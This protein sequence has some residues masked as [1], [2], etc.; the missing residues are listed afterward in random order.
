M[1]K[2]LGYEGSV[3]IVTRALKRSG[4]FTLPA[5]ETKIGDILIEP[6]QRELL[7]ELIRQE[8]RSE[9][10]GIKRASIPVDPHFTIHHITT[11]VSELA[12]D[13]GTDDD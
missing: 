9:G 4:S 5:P 10:F 13:A 2:T 8:V 12:G 1:S 11:A 3:R 7:R 6:S